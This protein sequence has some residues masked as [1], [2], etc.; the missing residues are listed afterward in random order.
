MKEKNFN[1]L[2]DLDIS[3]NVARHVKSESRR[4]GYAELEIILVAWV[5]SRSSDGLL[6]KHNYIKIKALVVAKDL[7][8]FDLASN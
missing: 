3:T 6:V 4:H 7:D 1:S 8:I 2:I 5:K